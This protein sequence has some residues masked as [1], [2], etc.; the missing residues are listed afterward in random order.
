MAALGCGPYIRGNAT[1]VMS[2]LDMGCEDNKGS[3]ELI[4]TSTG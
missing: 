1:A 2:V 3:E 4:M